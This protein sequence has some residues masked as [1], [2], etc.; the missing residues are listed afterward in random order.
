ML[1]TTV[2]QSLLP[3]TGAAQYPAE[4]RMLAQLEHCLHRGCVLAIEHTA[5]IE[6]R[7]AQWELWGTSSLYA[8]DLQAVHIEIDRCRQAHCNHHI[9]LCVEDWHWRSR[10]S[11]IVYRPHSTALY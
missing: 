4:S 5:R 7:T 9:R 10:L 11:V 6:P 8:G 2:V 3:I 1:A